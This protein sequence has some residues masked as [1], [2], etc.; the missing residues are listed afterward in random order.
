MEL[1]EGVLAGSKRSIARAISAIEAQRPI[2]R[3]LLSALYPHTGRAYRI[4]VTGATGTGKSTLVNQLARAYRARDLRVG[5]IGV[6]PS[7]PFSGGALLGDRIR[8]RDLAGDPGVYIRSMAT[9]GAI[10]GLA[11]TTCEAIHVLDAAGYPIIIVETV[12]AGQDEIEIAH[13]VHTTVYVDVPGMGDEIQAIKAGLVEIADVFVVNKADRDGA[14]RAVHVLE[15][16]LDLDERSWTPPVCKTIALDGTG[17]DDLVTA[18][19][20]HRAYLDR[21]ARQEKDREH[22]RVELKRLLQHELL[23]RFLDGIEPGQL[24]GVV[25]RIVSRELGPYDA[26]ME[27]GVSEPS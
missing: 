19:E 21:G 27:L 7:S 9:R 6:D 15:M 1:V 16:M 8:M 17:L 3:E 2:A 20:S 13:T 14:D 5:I 23:A 12:G 26:L 22:A 25:S 18:I 11:G 24:E 4:G 10:G